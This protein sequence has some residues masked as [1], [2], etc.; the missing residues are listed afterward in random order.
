MDDFPIKTSIYKGFSMALLNN[1]RV[2]NI[3]MD[4]HHIFDVFIHTWPIF[5]PCSQCNRRMEQ[6]TKIYPFGTAGWISFAYKPKELVWLTFW[7]LFGDW[8]NQTR[9]HKRWGDK[10]IPSGVRRKPVD[11]CLKFWKESYNWIQR[12]R[13]TDILDVLQPEGFSWNIMKPIFLRK[14]IVNQ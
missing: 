7:I 1:Q 9:S 6:Y 12:D 13:I 5:W 3:V 4:N 11:D 10:L 2:I 14:D 8:L